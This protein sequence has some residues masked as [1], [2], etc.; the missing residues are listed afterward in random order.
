[1]NP[2]YSVVYEAV[3][4]EGFLKCINYL[5]PTLVH[6]LFT[7]RPDFD[8]TRSAGDGRFASGIWHQYFSPDMKTISGESTKGAPIPPDHVVRHATISGYIFYTDKLA[9]PGFQKDCRQATGEN[10]HHFSQG[11]TT[12]LNDNRIGSGQIVGLAWPSVQN[13]LTGINYMIFDPAAIR[14]EGSGRFPGIL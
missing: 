1:M 3:G 6:T 2:D 5:L 12:F 13:G 11:F 10:P 14:D 7:G 4:A 8:S 9:H